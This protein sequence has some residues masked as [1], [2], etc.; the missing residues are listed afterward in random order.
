MGVRPV[1]AAHF[2]D[3]RSGHPAAHTRGRAP[4]GVVELRYSGRCLGATRRGVTLRL[5]P[6]ERRPGQTVVGPFWDSP[7]RLGGQQD[8][9]A[10]RQLDR[11]LR[12]LGRMHLTM[13][14]G[15]SRSRA[16]SGSASLR[17][18][19]AIRSGSA[20]MNACTVHRGRCGRT[21]ASSSARIA[22]DTAHPWCRRAWCRQQG[23]DARAREVL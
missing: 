10:G 20:M 1:G 17:T 11:L 22:A 23:E 21:G 15:S 2:G 4:G 14:N 8:L 18:S 9:V 5:R 6:C 16:A 7:G 3:G 19:G 13:K 12:D